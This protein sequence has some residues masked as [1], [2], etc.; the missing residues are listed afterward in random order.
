MRQF[1]DRVPKLRRPFIYGD[2]DARYGTENSELA[3]FREEMRAEETN[4]HYLEQDSGEPEAAGEEKVPRDP[5]ENLPPEDPPADDMTL[6][7]F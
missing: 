3:E 1:L 4:R 6:G 7:Y 5:P 2:K